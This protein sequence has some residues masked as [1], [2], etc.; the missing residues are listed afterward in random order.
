ME[1]ARMTES[2]RRNSGEDTSESERSTF[3]DNMYDK[4]YSPTYK[5]EDGS[6]VS[7]FDR[8]QAFSKAQMARSCARIN[9]EDED[10]A[11]R[12]AYDRHFIDLED[13][14]GQ[15]SRDFEYDPHWW[16]ND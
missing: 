9:G 16:R 3:L 4:G 15:F 2:L 12:A 6:D 13:E 1:S 7:S 14:N 8:V 10:S 11:A 5:N